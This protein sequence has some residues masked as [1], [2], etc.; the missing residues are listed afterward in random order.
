MTSLLLSLTPFIFIS[1]YFYLLKKTKFITFDLKL[2]K[3]C[4]SCKDEIDLDNNELI[5]ILLQ[6]K[7]NYRL[8]KACQREEK[9]YGL[10]NKNKTSILNKFK[11]H[12][13]DNESFKDKSKIAIFLM[14]LLFV[15]DI[16]LKIV[17][18]IKWF[19]YV[20]NTYITIYWS[21]FIYRHKLFQ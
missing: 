8:C 12:L 21:F 2:G 5:D 11:L 19:S 15:V 13:I 3:N 9:L 4:Y 20:Y 10:L 18:D 17:Y 7:K 1:Y 16:L 6:E 14:V